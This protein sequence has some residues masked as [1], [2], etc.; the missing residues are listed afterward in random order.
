MLRLNHM[1]AIFKTTKLAIGEDDSSP[2]LVTSLVFGLPD[3]FACRPEFHVAPSAGYHDCTTAWQLPGHAL[4][5]EFALFSCWPLWQLQKIN[6]FTVKSRTL[7][8]E[9]RIALA[10]VHRIWNVALCQSGFQRTTNGLFTMN[11]G[12]F[13]VKLCLVLSLVEEEVLATLCCYYWNQLFVLVLLGLRCHRAM[14]VLS[15][16]TTPFNVDNEQ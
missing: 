16:G 12:S 13:P 10:P 5:S 7:P 8:V 1:Y 11:C 3:T 9:S 2:L 6:S 15:D 14:K 4:W